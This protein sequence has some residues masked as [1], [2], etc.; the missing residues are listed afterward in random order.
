MKSAT[1]SSL[2]DSASSRAQAPQAGAAEKSIN[3]GLGVHIFLPID[4]HSATFL[5]RVSRSLER[6]KQRTWT[7]V[8][9][10]LWRTTAKDQTEPKGSIVSMVLHPSRIAL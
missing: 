2:Y 4:E 7:G 6:G 10:L 3:K 8:R 9:P 5:L 1:A